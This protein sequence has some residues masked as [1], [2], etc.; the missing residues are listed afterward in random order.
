MAVVADPDEKARAN[1]AFSRAATAC[2]KL[3]LKCVRRARK[4]PGSDF[5]Y[6]LGFELLVYSYTPMGLPTA[7]CAKVVEREI[8]INQQSFSR[9]EAMDHPHGFNDSTSG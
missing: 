5:V 1:L 6:R 2:S 4:G 8:W 3:S 9:A 7:V